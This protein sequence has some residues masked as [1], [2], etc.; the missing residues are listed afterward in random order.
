[1]DK[2]SNQLLQCWLL[3]EPVVELE[4]AWRGQHQCRA[5]GT[6]PLTPCM[7]VRRVLFE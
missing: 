1:M 4:I 3:R 2:L 6:G 7:V 5:R